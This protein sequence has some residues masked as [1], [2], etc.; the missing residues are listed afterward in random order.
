MRGIEDRKRRGSYTGLPNPVKRIRLSLCPEDEQNDICIV[1]SELEESK[2]RY[3]EYL[4]SENMM[5]YIFSSDPRDIAATDIQRVF[6]G[7]QKR[8]VFKKDLSSCFN[9]LIID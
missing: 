3:V 8:R 9:M 7:W 6:R 5:A 4:P 2:Y 1:V